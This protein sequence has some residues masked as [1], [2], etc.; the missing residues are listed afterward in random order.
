MKATYKE[1]RELLK[2]REPFKGNSVEAVYISG[3]SYKVYSYGTLIF[4]IDSK[5]N[6]ETF[7]LDNKFYSVTTSKIQNMLI[8]VFNLNN[9]VKKRD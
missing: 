8:E 9:G 2:S 3:G 5:H 1:M 6:G 7:H 4:E